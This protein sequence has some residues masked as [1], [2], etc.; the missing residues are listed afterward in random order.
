MGR[1]FFRGRAVWDWFMGAMEI[2][3]RK[4]NAGFA[5]FCTDHDPYTTEPQYLTSIAESRHEPCHY[6]ANIRKYLGDAVIFE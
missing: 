5:T 6:F 1:P 3:L 2:G 4:L